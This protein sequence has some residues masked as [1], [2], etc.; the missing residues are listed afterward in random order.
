MVSITQLK[1]LLAVHQTQHFGR[2]AADC[3][4]S[5]PALSAQIQKAESFLGITVFDRKATPVATTAHGLKV[6]EQARAVL[7]AHASVMKLGL[8]VEGRV[9][10]SFSLRVIPT[11]A[12]Y[13]LPWFLR[14]FAAR[15]PQVDLSLYEIT[16]DEL[17]DALSHSRL[18]AALLSTPLQEASIQERVLFYDPFYLYAHRDE[19]V[20]E[21]AEVDVTRLDPH[22]LWLLEDGHCLRT[23]VV[24][25]CGMAQPRSNLG[26]VRFAAGSLE[27]LVR[28]IDASEG[29]TLLPESHARSL[30]ARSRV[31]CLRPFANSTPTREVSLVHPRQSWKGPILDALQACIDHSV[32]RAL[33]RTD[34]AGVVM[35]IRPAG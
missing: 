2:A 4:V 18:D 32:P 19:P 20:L 11:L 30:P 7:S 6:I 10:G 22:K 16:T 34:P 23:Q 24:N 17:I 35:A 8:G 14:A 15:Y 9:S 1:Y 28:L 27:T 21:N 31:R 3:H 33:K 26:S 25:F 29:Y 5:Q 13:V 12:P